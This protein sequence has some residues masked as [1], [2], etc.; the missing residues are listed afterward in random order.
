MSKLDPAKCVESMIAVRKGLEE[1]S[2]SEGHPSPLEM[3]EAMET[4]TQGSISVL[5]VS[6]CHR[7]GHTPTSAELTLVLTESFPTMN[8]GER[9]GSYYLSLMRTGRLELPDGVPAPAGAVPKKPLEQ[10]ATSRP[11]GSKKIEK[12]KAKA[13]EKALAAKPVPTPEPPKSV[14]P[15]K[16]PEGDQ[17]EDPIAW[18]TDKLKAYLKERNV[19]TAGRARELISRARELRASESASS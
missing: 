14:E 6:A 3:V 2:Q 5:Y 18:S 9:H 7:A 1:L 12:L 11:S 16:P 4:Q 15:P 10:R 19:S 13:A 17:D 8:V